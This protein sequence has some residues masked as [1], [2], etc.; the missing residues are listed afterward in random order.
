MPEAASELEVFAAWTFV[1]FV[2]GFLLQRWAR[3]LIQF[4]RSP[5][6][7][8]RL[9]TRWPGLD[10]STLQFFLVAHHMDETA[11]GDAIERKVLSGGIPALIDVTVE[12]HGDKKLGCLLMGLP[13][14]IPSVSKVVPGG[15]VDRQLR[16]GDMI[17][18]VNGELAGDVVNAQ[19][20]LAEA[21]GVVRIEVHRSS[22]TKPVQDQGPG[23]TICEPHTAA[24]PA[25]EPAEALVA[26]D[27][28]T[29]RP[30]AEHDDGP[31]RRTRGEAA[32]D[33]LH[34]G[35]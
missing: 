5:G 13:A 34:V 15:L 35:T 31:R 30:S 12:K 21:T 27:C 22:A 23:R 24:V 11:A 25:H 33:A 19:R 2:G 28:D 18:R 32:G 14:H 7:F 4:I 9:Q 10:R 3:K 6:P 17:C 8:E 29:G 16:V 20:L 26:T 1:I